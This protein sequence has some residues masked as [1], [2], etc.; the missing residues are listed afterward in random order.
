MPLGPK[1]LERR[2]QGGDISIPSSPE[3]GPREEDSIKY[4][5]KRTKGIVMKIRHAAILFSLVPY[6]LVACIGDDVTELV[7]DAGHHDATLAD[8]STPPDVVAQDASDSAPPPAQRVLV[9]HTATKGELVAI[10]L[11]SGNVD[12]RLPFKQFGVV[13]SGAIPYLIESNVDIV[14]RLDPT[15][16]WAVTSTWNVSGNDMFDGGESY[17]DPV[18]VIQT[19]PN[20]AYVLRYNR[21]AIAVFDPSQTADGGAAAQYIS[22]QS[23]LQAG[24]K[25]RHVDMAGAI[26]DSTRKRIYIALA[27]IDLGLVDPQGYFQ[28]CSPTKSTLIA[29]DTTTD[30][31]VDLGGSGPGGGVVLN[32]RSPQLALSG[33]MAYDAVGDRV[34]VMSTG[35]NTITSDGGTGALVGR[36]IEAVTLMDNTPHTLLDLNTADFPGQ[37]LYLEQHTAYVQLGFPP[38]ASVFAW[39][40]TTTKLGAA[41]PVAPDTFGYD[42]KNNALV[43]PITPI[44]TDGGVAPA[45]VVSVSLA[46][47]GPDASTVKEL[48][49]NPFTEKGG[50]FGNATLY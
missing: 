18:Q 42:P 16:P 35:C 48:A 40:P 2:E 19:A 17:A 11:S 32:G 31:L 38:Y 24:D 27:N 49:P 44:L 13:Q 45:R 36:M 29:I 50:Y 12:G 3:T 41:L 30:K 34:L 14:A 39:D 6:G 20:K 8:V 21:N 23:L 26:Y 5:G 47:A 43:G 28:L 1:G 4:A 46:D 33:G 37:L 7:I 10:N 25:D 15:T 22:V 9:T